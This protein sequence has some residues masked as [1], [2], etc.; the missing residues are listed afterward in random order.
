MVNDPTHRRAIGKHPEAFS[1]GDIP[2]GCPGRKPIST[3]RVL[4]EVLWITQA[5]NGTSSRKAANHHEIR[6]V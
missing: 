3:R 4:E 6:L 1:G 5:R 2:D